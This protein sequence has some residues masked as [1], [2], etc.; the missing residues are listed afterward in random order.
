MF[1]GQWVWRLDDAGVTVGY[2][3]R[4]AKL[5]E[6]PPRSLGAAVY[7]TRTGYTYFFKRESF[8]TCQLFLRSTSCSKGIVFIHRNF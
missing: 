5:F 8:V 2:P 7:S 6:K 4:A 3:Q 1:R